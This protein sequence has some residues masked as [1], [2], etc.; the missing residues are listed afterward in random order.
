M[1]FSLPQS[2]LSIDGPHLRIGRPGIPVIALDA[3][4]FDDAEA[5]RDRGGLAVAM[6]AAS[7]GVTAL[8]AAMVGGAALVV[9]ALLGI[10]TTARATAWMIGEGQ[11]SL[12]LDLG[13]LRVAVQI[14]DG[15]RA[16]GRVAAALRP[17]TRSAP[18]ADPAAYEDVRR[19]LD[20]ALAGRP[21][22]RSNDAASAPV[23]VGEDQVRLVGDSLHVGV[24][25]FPISLVRE[26]A[27]RGENLP[28]D[29]D[30]A[31]QAALALL[32]VAAEER[33]QLVEEPRGLRARLAAYEKWSGR[34]ANR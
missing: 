15:P 11:G 4:L 22:P 23:A 13:R 14:H 16:A 10:L 2:G 6:G 1:A 18:L 17:W 5:E 31:V 27:Q 21:P 9:P 7:T 8:A 33:S 25:S 3:R 26:L 34:V 29:G 28:L 19:R 24:R 20:A 30:G 32:V 12:R